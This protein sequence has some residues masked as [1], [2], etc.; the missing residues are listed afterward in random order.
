MARLLIIDDNPALVLDQVNHVFGAAGHE[1]TVART[2]KEGVRRAAERPPDAVLLDLRLPDL[3]GM[4]VYHRIH[5]ADARIPVIFITAATDAD[6][7]IE[8]MRR[9]ALEHPLQPLALRTMRSPGPA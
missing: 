8:A 5:E 7:A 9:G 2:G 3:P 4:E 6:S 1:I